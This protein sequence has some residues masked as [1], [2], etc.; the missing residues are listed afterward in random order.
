MNDFQTDFLSRRKHY[1][2][3]RNNVR[4][5]FFFF[6]SVLFVF[7]VHFLLRLPSKKPLIIEIAKSY[8]SKDEYIS[9]NISKQ[10][11]G[12]NFFF[13]SP[14]VVTKNLILS[15][16]LLKDVVVRKY[17]FPKLKLLIFVKEKQLWGKLI[18]NNENYPIYITNEGNLV[19]G[20]YINLKLLPV[21]LTLVLCRNSKLLPE[22]VLL[23]LKDVL[24]F[25]NTNLKIK[26]NKFLVTDKNT[27]EIYTDN[28]IT[29]NAG[30][31][32]SNILKKITKLTEILTQIK[33]NSYLIQY[34]NLSLENGAVIKKADDKKIN[35]KS[36]KSFMILH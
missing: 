7:S 35:K 14:R 36:I 20:D 1:R 21:D 18:T 34:I 8:L 17:L 26:I 29:I 16:G 10:V 5:F 6:F 19:S 33:K 3:R 30:Y 24:D 12:K 11:A 15:S 25:F 13:I 27:L 4:K 23:I 9:Q 28:S 2:E 22:G 31:I 32:D